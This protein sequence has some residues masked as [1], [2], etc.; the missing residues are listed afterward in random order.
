MKRL[1]TFI[2]TFFLIISILPLSN[3]S[4]SQTSSS[5]TSFSG[6]LASKTIELSG[7]QVNNSATID[8]PRNVTFTSAG[9]DLDFDQTDSSPGQISVDIY[10]DGILEWNY[11]GQGYGN[12]GEQT[13]F[14]D[15]SNFF[16][17]PT[18]AGNSSVPG[19]M[20]P[21]SGVLQSS[22]LNASFTP[23]AG[24]GFYEIGGFTDIVESDID[25]DGYPEPCLLYTSPSPRD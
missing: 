6:G 2:I 25:S 22:T 12:I 20:L 1:N 15:G 23:Q 18:N 5:I 11:S 10:E 17:Q 7:G 21:S 24:G 4:A 3:I 14:Y 13:T 16:V 9:F 19:V 8:I